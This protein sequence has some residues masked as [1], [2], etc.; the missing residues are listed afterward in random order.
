MNRSRL[1]R[2]VMRFAGLTAGAVTWAFGTELSQLL[3]YVDC[4]RR[5]PLL[6]VSTFSLSAVAFFGAYLSWCCRTDPSDVGPTGVETRLF[7]QRL[8]ALAAALFGFALLLQ[9]T[10]TLV[11][12]ACER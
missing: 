9:G 6:A 2:N 12:S 11:V 8:S 1:Q 5:L 3:P 7:S 4:A 10:A